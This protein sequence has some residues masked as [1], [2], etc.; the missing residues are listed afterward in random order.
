LRAVAILQARVQVQ[1]STLNATEEHVQGSQALPG[2]SVDI[3]E[4]ATKLRELEWAL[5]L[6]ADQDF[7]QEKSGFIESETVQQY[8][9]ST[10]S[11]ASDDDFS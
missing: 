7:E 4:T 10:N 5:L 3:W 1:L 9:K 6:R 11:A 8:L 2:V